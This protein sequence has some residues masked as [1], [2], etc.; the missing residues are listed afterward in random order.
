MRFRGARFDAAFFVVAV[1]RV[2]SKRAVVAM[3]LPRTKDDRMSFRC[4]QIESDF[5][6]S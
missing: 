6:N 4:G 3:L 5:R 1:F 2:D